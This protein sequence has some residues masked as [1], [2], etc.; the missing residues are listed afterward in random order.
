MDIFWGMKSNVSKPVI[1][2]DV[3]LTDVCVWIQVEKDSKCAVFGLGAVGLAAVMGCKA[4]EAKTIIGID[5][6]PAR[7]E[8][9]MLLGATGC[10]N[11]S[12]YNKSIQEVIV[13]LSQGGVDYALECVGSPAVMVGV[14]NYDVLFHKHYQLR[15]PV[16]LSF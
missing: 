2:T 6:N 7:F 14:Q 1:S 3:C 8:K 13:E 16:F 15:L 5:V 11:P 4:A 9:A 12:N 10:V